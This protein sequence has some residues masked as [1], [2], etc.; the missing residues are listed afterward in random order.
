MV[1]CKRLE[2]TPV[3]QFTWVQSENAGIKTAFICE[4]AIVRMK[5]QNLSKKEYTNLLSYIEEPKKFDLHNH[6]VCVIKREKLFKLATIYYREV[7][8]TRIIL[9][10]H[11]HLNQGDN[12]WRTK[13]QVIEDTNRM[14]GE[15]GCYEK[16]LVMGGYVRLKKHVM[17]GTKGV[18][19]SVKVYKK[20]E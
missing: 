13:E 12:G 16:Q 6:N 3:R 15:A 18:K 11:Y 1:L 20:V 7:D 5:F 8:E 4:R 2:Y 14:L 9:D 10:I 17:R 19:H